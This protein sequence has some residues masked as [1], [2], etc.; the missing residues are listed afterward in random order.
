MVGNQVLVNTQLVNH[1]DNPIK[2]PIKGVSVTDI[3]YV[4]TDEYW[5][6]WK[7][8]INTSPNPYIKMEGFG[9]FVLRYSRARN[10]MRL[11]LSKIKWYRVKHADK[12]QNPET[13]AGAV[14]QAMVN[15]FKVLWIQGDQ[16]K[17]E[18]NERIARWKQ[19]KAKRELNEQV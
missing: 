8:K 14:Y 2:E 4:I 10:Y 3:I 15:R 9:L 18:Y 1:P 16:V 13:R 6:Q 7:K 19:K 12:Y 11:L 17:H 5:K